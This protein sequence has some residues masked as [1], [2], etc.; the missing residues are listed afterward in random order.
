MKQ[1][2]FLTRIRANTALKRHILTTIAVI[3]PALVVTGCQTIS[4]QNQAP[5][6]VTAPTTRAPAPV[7]QPESWSAGDY[8]ARAQASTGMEQIQWQ[9]QAA[10]AFIESFDYTAAESLLDTIDYNALPKN[11][12]GLYTISESELLLANHRYTEALSILTTN[13]R[14]LF[15]FIDQLPPMQQRK[16][17]Y[18]RARA[19]ETS[20]QYLAA[21]RERVFIGS[22]ISDPNEA[23]HN[24][25][26]IWRNLNRVKP[27]TLNSLSASVPDAQLRG[28]I[29]L[30]ALTRDA[31]GG[32]LGRLEGVSQW[33][34][35]WQG[36][37]A[38]R[39]PPKSLAVLE[40]VV[41]ERPTTVAILL[42][43]GG[44]FGTAAQV[45]REGFM[46]SHHAD[47][48]NAEKPPVLVFIDTDTPDSTQSL[49][50]R[51][52]VAGAEMIIGPLEKQ[53]VADLMTLGPLPIPTLSLNYLPDQTYQQQNLFQ[54]GLAAEDEAIQIAEHAAMSGYKISG[55]LFPD[56]DWGHRIRQ[57]FDQAW[58]SLGGITS[59][60]TPYVGDRD[61]S[62]TI[63]KMM[64]VDKSEARA[65]EL[66][67][68]IKRKI[69]FTPRRRQDMEFLVVLGNPPQARQ[70]KPALDFYFAGNLPIF[71]TS[72]IY[73]GRPD[74]DR[75]KDLDGIAFTDIPWL[76]EEARPITGVPTAQEQVLPR[77][78][79]LGADAYALTLQL[80]L[81]RRAQNAFHI[82]HTG[83]LSLDTNQRIRREVVWAEF[84]RGR[85]MLK[86]MQSETAS[87]RTP[88]TTPLFVTQKD[89]T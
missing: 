86:K 9:L 82:G 57:A 37:P 32:L 28:W 85:P 83:R 58:L 88:H 68:V 43:S 70:L 22:S 72:N 19:H 78:F 67:S 14:G 53:R 45:M 13:K 30:V 79:A 6:V 59:E 48:A 39:F 21:T 18:L 60:A 69:S 3:T 23:Q 74:P 77:L 16:L 80:N 15:S 29:E 10:L 36:H 12:K 5:R 84:N 26:V 89:P 11:L 54:F 44:R 40:Q 31:G 71:S 33:R 76:F 52:L 56:T 65:R 24:N 34:T 47:L 35:R 73:A 51:A 27:S 42:P 75:D 25:E 62:D 87:Q 64:Q 55:I 2:T 8:L 7:T 61:F 50:D 66:R 1:S 20:G 17:Q 63:K 41:A 4:P 81:L 38:D 46:A 49:Y